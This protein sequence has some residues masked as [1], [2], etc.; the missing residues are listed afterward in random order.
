MKGAIA[1]FAENHVAAN[2]LMLFLIFA[3][4]LTLT[5]IKLEVFPETSL[6]RISI[7]TEYPGAS[8][9][10]VEEAV[11]R[12]IEERLAGLAGIK[13]IDSTAREGLGTI[14]IEVIKGWDV[15]SLLDE[16]KAEVDRITTLPDEA[17]KPVVREVTARVQVINIAVYGDAQESTIKYL[18]E[19]IKDDI[20]NLPGVT[21]ADI[22]GIRSGEVHIEI[23]EKTLRRHDLTLGQVADTV[24]RASL[25]LPAGSVKTEGGE[26]LIRTK[27]RRYYADEFAD[28][29]VITRADGSKVTLEQIA[30]VSDGYE[31]VDLFARF[32][33]KPASVI[34][35]YRVADQNALTVAKTVKGYIA[36]IKPQLPAGVD[37]EFFADM[38]D[39]LRSRVELLLRNMTI[40]LV[41]VILI[42][43]TFLSIRLSFWVTLGIPIS[44]LTG[45]AILP[46]F[47]VTINMIS[48]FAFI[49]VLGIV[50][51]DAIIIGENIFQ[52]QERGLPPLEAAKTGA[53][54]VGLPV[55]FSV[56]TTMVAFAPLMMGGGMMGKLLRNIPLVVIVVLFASLVESLFILPAHLSRSKQSRLIHN[57]KMKEKRTARWLKEFI[58]GPY[59]RAISFCTRWRY[60]TVALGIA[61][62]LVIAGMLQ[63]GII[64]FTFFPKVE[65]D[66]LECSLTM[67]AGT[68]V[69]RTIEVVRHLEEAARKTLED[70]DKK[71][72]KGAPKLFQHSVA[73][74]GT[75]IGDDHGGMST[76][77]GHLAHIWIQVLKG[78]ERKA[79]TATL[80]VQWRNAVGT[81]PDVDSM[82]FKSILHSAGK[83]V[84]V[85]LSLEDYDNLLA[86]ADDLKEELKRYPGVYD[87]SDSFLPGKKEMQLKLKPA[88]R[89]LGVTLNDL[90]QQVRHAFYGA[91][92]LRMQRGK[93]EVKVLV[94]Y[95]ED[96]RKSLGYV[97]EMRIRTPDGSE[98]PFSLL[99]DVTMK[100]GYVSIER[101]QRNRVIKVYAD[102]D[103][104]VTNAN[105]VRNTLEKG[106]LQDLK[107]RYPGLR[108]SIEGEGKEQKESLDDV[109]LGFIFALFC[110][111]ALLAV[112][113]RSFT[114]PLVVMAAI[115]FGI[116]G[117]VLGHLIMGLNI[118]ILSLFGVVGLAGVVVNDSLVLI[119]ATNRLRRE[120]ASPQEAVTQ[121]GGLRF[122]AIILTSLTTFGGLMPMILERS[123]QAKFLIP[124]A[125]SLGYGVLFATVITLLLIPCLYLI[126]EDIHN[127]TEKIKVR[128]AR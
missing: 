92:A 65:S 37:I 57:G 21:L 117:A 12:R 26:I 116:V 102:V 112:P 35:V 69:E 86:A 29:A 110:I 55:I 62:L 18:T 124:M 8:P 38:S 5:T 107:F 63:G 71:A 109:R 113:F 50:V 30:S 28:I 44:F 118:T 6:D 101:T 2:L 88:A 17:E 70:A 115:P 98:V 91:E 31:N 72:P 67:P 103:E 11:I 125:V 43:G 39:I 121:A 64:K 24:R 59:A 7:T 10:E 95:P 58:S 94:R 66:T 114:Q 79:S 122:R 111:Y 90:A 47:D 100:Q 1:W 51:D 83:S 123:L 127:V 33:G 40:G 14:T 45:L 27:G 108:Y 61:L 42:L 9:A 13:R 25:D 16:V 87:V 74:I 97:E 60:A 53:I 20:T 77:G 56:L 34:Q 76:P 89:S 49:M 46:H 119:H 128:L 3:G 82:T 32:Q 106:F 36:A 22:F 52:E 23:S 75:Q 120:G 48:L 54:E 4:V 96:E 85:H 105:E 84:E 15:K 99:A 80:A 19:K 73:L 41:L 81:I 104:T 126:L 93:D 78:E 68:P